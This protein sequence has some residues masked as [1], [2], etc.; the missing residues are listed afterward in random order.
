[1]AINPISA[2]SFKGLWEVNTIN[3][4]QYRGNHI[5]KNFVYHPFADEK[6]DTVDLEAKKKMVSG[7][8]SCTE[9]DDYD[10]EYKH[11]IVNR[12]TIGDTLSVTA[13]KYFTEV[14]DI[15]K[16]F[17]KGLK[18]MENS[19]MIEQVIPDKMEF[20]KSEF[21]SDYTDVKKVS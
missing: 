7:V 13:E 1:M 17:G 3:P 19:E 21:L 5:Q 10:R 12:F 20:G 14:K 11:T 9:Y 15:V 18:F 4:R 6:V 16:E 2:T 8:Y